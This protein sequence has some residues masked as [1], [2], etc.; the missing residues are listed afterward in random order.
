MKTEQFDILIVATFYLLNKFQSEP[1]VALAVHIVE[2]LEML[3]QEPKVLSSPT[4]KHSCSKMLEEWGMA[5]ERHQSGMPLSCPK[6]CFAS[7]H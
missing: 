1:K 2:H 3:L 7:L 5:V 4:L 6:N